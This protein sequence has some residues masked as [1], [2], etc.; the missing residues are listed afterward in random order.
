MGMA[1]S[2]AFLVTR[3]EPRTRTALLVAGIALYHQIAMLERSETR[4]SC[5]VDGIV[6]FDSCSRAGGR[7]GAA[8]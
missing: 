3:S 6:Y 7:N 8:A 2:G 1:T 4:L 5:L